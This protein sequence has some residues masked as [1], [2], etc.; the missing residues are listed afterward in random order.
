V[1]LVGYLIR[2]IFHVF[3][4][5]E[6]GDDFGCELIACC[7]EGMPVPASATAGISLEFTAVPAASQKCNEQY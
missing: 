4:C 7:I 5:P 3:L 1:R 2:K 6:A